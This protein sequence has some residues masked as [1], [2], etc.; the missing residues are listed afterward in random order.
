MC[1]A[2]I[3][4]CLIHNPYFGL[5]LFNPNCICSSIS[6]IYF[7]RKHLCLIFIHVILNVVLLYLTF[8]SNFFI[9]YQFA[10]TTFQCIII[11][12]ILLKQKCK[13]IALV[14][15]I[16]AFFQGY[17]IYCFT[18]NTCVF[19]QAS[20]ISQSQYEGNTSWLYI[21]QVYE[22]LINDKYNHYG[23][24]EGIN[25]L[26]EHN[27]IP[28]SSI[29]QMLYNLPPA[30]KTLHFH[31]HTN[32][33]YKT[34]LGFIKSIPYYSHLLCQDMAKEIDCSVLCS[35]NSSV[36]QLRNA[37][38]NDTYLISKL[39]AYNIEVMRLNTIIHNENRFRC[40]NKLNDNLYLCDWNHHFKQAILNEKI[41]ILQLLYSNPLSLKGDFWQLQADNLS[42]FDFYKVEYITSPYLYINKILRERQSIIDFNYYC[43]SSLSAKNYQTSTRKFLDTFQQRHFYIS[44][45]LG[46]SLAEVDTKLGTISDLENQLLSSSE[47]QGF[48]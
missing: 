40:C 15:V 3:Y 18:N 6:I 43:Y 7:C 12:L 48:R 28:G 13:M 23:N 27:I 24:Y 9:V 37:L 26:D 22:K 34:K 11:F 35:D 19:S 44:W 36:V 47:S 4:K 32:Y 2:Q 41:A 14:M 25:L 29:R 20:S 39:V 42:V 10:I 30:T 31:S 8:R 21:K 5:L 38:L 17:I 1:K 16:F 45:L 46:S 33:I